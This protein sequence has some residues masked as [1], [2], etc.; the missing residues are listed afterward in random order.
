MPPPQSK[1]A[2][3]DSEKRVLKQWIAAGAGYTAHWAFVAP[4]KAPPPEVRQSEWPRNHIDA[5]ILARLEKERLKPSPPA[6]RATLIRRLSLDLIGLPPTPEEVDAFLLDNS[7]NAYASLVHRL[8][9]SPHYGERRA[10]RWLDLARYADTN[11]YEKDRGRSIWPYRDWVIGAINADMPFDRF[12]IE[13]LAGDML[14][15]DSPASKIATGFHRNTMLNEE[16]GIDPLEFRFYAMTD[17]VATT[18]TTWLGLTLGC[19]QCHTHK[20]DP[21]PHREYYQFMALLNNADE[22]VWTVP[23]PKSESRRAE[24]ERAIASRV[25]D[26]PNR[27]PVPD[28]PAD[29]RSIEERR[30]EIL[31]RKFHEWVASE[32]KM[33]VDWTTLRPIE[34]TANVPTLTLRGRWHRLCEWRSEQTRC[35]YPQISV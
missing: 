26:L 9:A 16:G 7:P 12:T 17:R 27:F 24:I 23:D 19:A 5:F 22:P 3:S 1:L 34:A 15:G 14:P 4:K 13:Q 18:A 11:G 33:A 30:K 6:D 10:R 8:L 32:E 29:T 2:L 31:E 20:Y 25:D 28:Q 35:L 21:I